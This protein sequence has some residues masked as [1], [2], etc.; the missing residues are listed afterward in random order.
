VPA[1]PQLRL[2]HLSRLRRP[3]D[4]SG[5]QIYKHPL[6]FATIGVNVGGKAADDEPFQY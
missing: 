6:S 4:L 5:L 2:Q 1:S 3:L